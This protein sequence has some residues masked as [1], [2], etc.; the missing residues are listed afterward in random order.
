MCLP[1]PGGVDC[2]DALEHREGYLVPTPSLDANSVRRQD[3]AFRVNPCLPLRSSFRLM[4]V[5]PPEYHLPGCHRRPSEQQRRRLLYTYRMCVCVPRRSSFRV[6]VR[7]AKH[8]LP[9][10]HRR[11]SQ[12]QRRRL[13]YIYIM[14]PHFVSCV[15]GPPNTI[16]LGAI[17]GP[18]SSNG[19]A[20]SI[21]IVCVCVFPVVPHFV[22]VSGPPNTIS[23]GATG[24][25]V[26]N[27]GDAFSLHSVFVC[28]PPRYSPDGV[29]YPG[30]RSSVGRRFRSVTKLRLEW[31]GGVF[32]L[33]Q[34]RS[35]HPRGM[36]I[37]RK[38]ATSHFVCVCQVPQTPSPWVQL[39]Q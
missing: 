38:A 8:H 21:H 1:M 20:F 3:I 10:R 14:F 13:L 31:Y 11:A 7:P 28:V 17:G 6:C 15:S 34:Q 18:V 30:A 29:R 27:N 9:G 23:L 22:C 25:P 26:S 39:G 19:D 2:L 24:G 32:V 12:Q 16:S 4:C 37:T 5:R 36:V 33:L 35:K